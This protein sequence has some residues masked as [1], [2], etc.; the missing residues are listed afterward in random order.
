MHASLSVITVSN[1]IG[2]IVRK[3]LRMC[4]QIW[5]KS[6]NI[7][8]SAQTWIKNLARFLGGINHPKQIQN[9]KISK[10]VSASDQAKRN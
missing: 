5:S 9:L 3:Y 7:D 1:M 4:W 8:N 2:L 10:N 6:R